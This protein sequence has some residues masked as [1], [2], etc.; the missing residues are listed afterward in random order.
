[1]TQ[2]AGGEW[3]AQWLWLR[4]LRVERARLALRQAGQAEAVARAAVEER[5]RRIEQG[6]DSLA[7]L[8]RD[9]S[10]SE[11]LPRWSGA[12][13]QWREALADRLERDEYEL[14]EEER[15]LEE[16]LDALQRCR[17]ELVRAMAR[18]EAVGEWVQ[19]ER[20]EEGRVRERRAERE[21]EERCHVSKECP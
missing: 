10:A 6:R 9:W 15:S 12:V 21:Q 5:M 13:T 17:D 7:A 8:A 11:G 18:H 3:H 2:A 16:A 19:Q 20:R 1:M 14:V 4:S